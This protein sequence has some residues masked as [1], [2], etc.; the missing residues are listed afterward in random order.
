MPRVSTFDLV[1]YNNVYINSRQKFD[2]IDPAASLSITNRAYRL[3]Y[4]GQ[5]ARH[6]DWISP[7]PTN[8]DRCRDHG[9]LYANS[10]G[11]DVA[12]WRLYSQR[13]AACEMTESTID[14]ESGMEMVLLIFMAAG[15]LSY[16]QRERDR[17]LQRVRVKDNDDPRRIRVIRH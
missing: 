17:M 5:W 8:R 7:P 1:C 4:P 12:E 13:S 10:A 6:D 16:I 9:R 11:K 2:I 3:D 15:A 14:K